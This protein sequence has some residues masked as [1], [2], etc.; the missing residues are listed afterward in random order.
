M[1]YNNCKGV[2]KVNGE[3]LMNNCERCGC[4]KLDSYGSFCPNC[5]YAI[6]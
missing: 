1:K 3:I 2:D 4:I 5:D 6:D